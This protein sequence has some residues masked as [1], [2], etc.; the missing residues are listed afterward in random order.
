M[1]VSV[2]GKHNL[3]HGTVPKYHIGDVLESNC[4]L[5]PEYEVALISNI[6]S[7][8]DGKSLTKI[9]KMNGISVAGDCGYPTVRHDEMEKFITGGLFNGFDEIWFLKNTAG[10]IEMPNL[11]LPPCTS[12]AIVFSKGMHEKIIGH[13]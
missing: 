11:L 9:L 7:T 6:D 2:R 10:I 1:S 13:L 12:D 5:L 4:D 8:R 3:I